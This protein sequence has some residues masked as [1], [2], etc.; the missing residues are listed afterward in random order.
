MKPPFFVVLESTLS[1][2][3]KFQMELIK[4][5]KNWDLKFTYLNL[6]CYICSFLI[7]FFQ[8]LQGLW[9]LQIYI[10]HMEQRGI[11]TMEWVCFSSMLPSLISTTMALFTPGKLMAVNSI[12]CALLNL[13]CLQLLYH[14]QTAASAAEPLVSRISFP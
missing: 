12:L 7:H 6:L 5:I 2:A 9:L 8:I 3:M 14:V 13:L 1:V 11:V 10:I 4:L